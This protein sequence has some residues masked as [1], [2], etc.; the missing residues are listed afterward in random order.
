MGFYGCV[1]C[2]ETDCFLCYF[3]LFV[4]FLSLFFVLCSCF[5]GRGC[6]FVF[7]LIELLCF[8]FRNVS[9][10]MFCFLESIFVFV[11]VW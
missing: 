8:C 4:V 11:F 1:F 3:G 5:F 6:V 2:L 10:L 9:S 7:F